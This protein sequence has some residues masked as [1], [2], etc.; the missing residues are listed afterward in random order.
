[1]LSRLL[2]KEAENIYLSRENIM[3]N[4]IP[5]P[6]SESMRSEDV[7]SGPASTNI[8]IKITRYYKNFIFLMRFVMKCLLL[9]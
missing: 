9:L 8:F 6:L 7:V 4:L 1:M 2:A 3:R 5:H